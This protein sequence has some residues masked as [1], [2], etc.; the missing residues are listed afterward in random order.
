MK[1]RKLQML[2]LLKDLHLV[3]ETDLHLVIETDPYLVKEM[4][5]W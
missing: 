4:V 1:G 2:E 5:L 3:T